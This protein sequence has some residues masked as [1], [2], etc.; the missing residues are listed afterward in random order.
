MLHFYLNASAAGSLAP[1]NIK[2]LEEQKKELFLL[3]NQKMYSENCLIN[4][5]NHM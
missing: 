3:P 5:F 4:Q 1:W 2:V